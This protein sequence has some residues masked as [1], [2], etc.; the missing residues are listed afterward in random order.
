MAETSRAGWGCLREPWGKM[1]RAVEIARSKVT[2]EERKMVV[3]CEE[4]TWARRWK[5][6]GG[7]GGERWGGMA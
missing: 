6:D 5:L 1:G 2:W 4:R 7:K 3:A